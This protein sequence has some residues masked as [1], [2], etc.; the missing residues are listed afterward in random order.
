MASSDESSIAS[1]HEAGNDEAS[2]DEASSDEK[3]R[4]RL[5]LTNA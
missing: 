2:S 5:L 3:T 4:V 1:E